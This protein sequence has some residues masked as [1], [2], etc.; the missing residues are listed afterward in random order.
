MPAPTRA[1]QRVGKSVRTFTRRYTDA[2]RCVPLLHACCPSHSPPQRRGNCSAE[3]QREQ[4]RTQQAR[5]EA[6]RRALN[7]KRSAYVSLPHV[8]VRVVDSAR[9]AV[10]E[11]SLEELIELSTDARAP[12]Q[13]LPE[14]LLTYRSFCTPS[15]LL[16]AW[17]HRLRHAPEGA[18]KE[19]VQY[20]AINAVKTWI[21]KYW[22]DFRRDYDAHLLALL[23]CAESYRPSQPQQHSDRDED[24]E[25]P[26]VQQ[27]AAQPSPQDSH[28]K[29]HKA[30]LDLVEHAKRR[31]ERRDEAVPEQTQRIPPPPA[32]L[33]KN[34]FGTFK[35]LDV[36]PLELARQLTLIESELF[37]QIEPWE[38]FNQAWM[39]VTKERDA[40]NI[41]QLIAHFNN[42]NGWIKYELLSE[43]DPETRRA[44][45]LYFLK[46]VA[47]RALPSCSSPHRSLAWHSICASYR[48]LTGSWSSRRR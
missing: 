7:T 36:H 31:Q 15:Q 6:R 16:A 44:K 33:P 37:R 8:A 10:K 47:V 13:L 34:V 38:F 27:H 29:L 25:Q 32:L 42:T 41:V 40:P 12:P 21:T 19:L 30:L 18:H 2:S 14:V 43:P 1:L 5:G 11:A 45:F 3:W 39:S 4:Q 24:E 9:A 22:F 26:R 28:S 20:R 35:L 17:L 46:V 23:T 48:T